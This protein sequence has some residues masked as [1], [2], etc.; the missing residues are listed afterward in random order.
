MDSK[1][2]HVRPNNSQFNKTKHSYELSFTAA[3]EVVPCRE[4]VLHLRS[5]T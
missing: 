1:Q 4:Q 5:F 3:T 2:A